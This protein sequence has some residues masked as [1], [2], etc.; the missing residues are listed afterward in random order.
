M[1][2]L[3]T[4]T[5]QHLGYLFY[6]VSAADKN[7]VQTEIETLKKIIQQYWLPLDDT[8]DFYGV[9]AAYQI[10]IVFDW[11]Q[12]SEPIALTCYQQF[13]DYYKTHKSIF[14]PKLKKLILETAEAIAHS[15]SGKNKSEL[16]LLAKLSVLFKE[17]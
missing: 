1:I 9:D 17:L 11:L 7:V 3:S 4:K 12:E 10:E 2:P 6:A 16:M 15:F 13:E 8:N 14:T 5:Y